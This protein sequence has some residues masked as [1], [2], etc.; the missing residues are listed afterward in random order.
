MRRGRG[1]GGR[2]PVGRTQISPLLRLNLET[3]LFIPS[4]ENLF[5]TL[6]R[7]AHAANW[8]GAYLI[9]KRACPQYV[10]SLLDRELS[11]RRPEGTRYS[12]E[13]SA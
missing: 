13:D 5:T 7:L 6:I 1:G 10:D 4:G 12:Y 2:R 8:G 11:P 3:D 9:D